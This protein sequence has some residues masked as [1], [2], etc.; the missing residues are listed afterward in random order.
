MILHCCLQAIII[1][2]RGMELRPFLLHVYSVNTFTT[3]GKGY[4][5]RGGNESEYH[6]DYLHWYFFKSAGV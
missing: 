3:K 2:R 6:F 4:F 5:I 1:S